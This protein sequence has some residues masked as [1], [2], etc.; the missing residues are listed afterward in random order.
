MIAL[1]QVEEGDQLKLLEIYAQGIATGHA[2]FEEKPPTWE[3]WKQKHI[4]SSSI[5]ALEEGDIVG[6]A[7]LSPFSIHSYYH[8]VA[9]TSIYVE[10]GHAGKGIGRLLLTSLVD[11]SE[12]NDIWSLTALIFPENQASVTLHELCGFRQIGRR[13]RLARMGYGPM[14]GQWRDVLLLERRSLRVG[15]A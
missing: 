2:T 3:E 12:K 15:R 13:E 7:A 4:A 9:E 1:R 5:V 14:E 8:G 10:P 11:S 6:W